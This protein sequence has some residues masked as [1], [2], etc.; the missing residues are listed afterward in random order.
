MTDR[1]YSNLPGINAPQKNTENNQAGGLPV[2]LIKETGWEYYLFLGGIWAAMSGTGYAVP[3][4]CGRG[5]SSR[6]ALGADECQP[7]QV[8]DVPSLS[9]RRNWPLTSRPS[10]GQY[11]TMCG[12]NSQLSTACSTSSKSTGGAA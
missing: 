2:N 1:I 4:G 3:L 11:R 10:L 6:W 5:E 12:D 8:H 9:T 7:T